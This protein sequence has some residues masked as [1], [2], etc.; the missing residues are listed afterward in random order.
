MKFSCSVLIDLPRE[1]VITLFNNPNN[2]S[3][4]QDGFVRLENINGTHG[5]VGSKNKITYDQ[6]GKEM[7]LIETLKVYNLPYEISGSYEHKMMDNEMQNLFT[8]VSPTQ[9]RWV[10]NIHYTRMKSFLKVIAFINPSM[11]KKQVQKWM[12]QFKAFAETGIS[13]A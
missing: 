5:D 11:F 7:I 8:E 3:H 13:I 10:A 12:D 1:K 6:K 2:M 4:W 9:T